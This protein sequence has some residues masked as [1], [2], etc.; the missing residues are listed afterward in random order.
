MNWH[1]LIAREMG[2]KHSDTLAVVHW[3]RQAKRG[4]RRR[5]RRLRKRF[6]REAEK[7]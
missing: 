4:T 6:I 3:G 5:L 2:I 7:D 1:Q